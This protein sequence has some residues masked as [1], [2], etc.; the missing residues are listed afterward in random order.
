MSVALRI[1]VGSEAAR[2]MDDGTKPH[3]IEAI[4]VNAEGGITLASRGRHDAVRCRQCEWERSRIVSWR[5][6]GGGEAE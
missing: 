4:H 6:T 2:L 1:R 5:P 3:F